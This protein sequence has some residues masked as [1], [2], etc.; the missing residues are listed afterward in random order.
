MGKGRKV[1]PYFTKSLINRYIHLISGVYYS[2]PPF[3]YNGNKEEKKRRL[4]NMEPKE[5][6]DEDSKFEGLK[7]RYKA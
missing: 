4:K 2:R 1:C 3:E 7:D 5:T 6:V